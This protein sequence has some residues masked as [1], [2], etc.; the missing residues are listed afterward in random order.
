MEKPHFELGFSA[1]AEVK[2]E[3]KAQII[4]I[5]NT[6]EDL[7]DDKKQEI[8]N[9]IAAQASEESWNDIEIYRRIEELVENL[10]I[11][12]PEK[13]AQRL[14]EP[15]GHE[16]DRTKHELIAVSKPPDLPTKREKNFLPATDVLTVL[17]SEMEPSDFAFLTELLSKAEQAKPEQKIVLPFFS[18]EE[19]IARLPVI[20]KNIAFLK[21]KYTV[22]GKIILPPIHIKKIA[23]RGDRIV[24]LFIKRNWKKIGPVSFF[25]KY[26]EI[27]GQ[28]SRNK[29]YKFD[30][31]LYRVLSRNNQLD[32][33]IP[34]KK[35][36]GRKPV[37]SP[38]QNK[39]IMEANSLKM[40]VAQAAQYAGVD[41]ATISRYWRKAG[42]KPHHWRKIT[43]QALTELFWR[44][45]GNTYQAEKLCQQ[46]LNQG[47]IYGHWKK[48]GL[49][50]ILDK[51]REAY[52]MGLN[53][54]QTAE[55]IG[56][57]EEF[58]AACWRR[59]RFLHP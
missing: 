20:K 24:I 32:Q 58:V 54:T 35:V 49:V 50:E 17:K 55:Y 4:Q 31:A 42:L 44:S 51:V 52:K 39:R 16:T 23:F 30:Q 40:T 43:I 59:H 13:Y 48:M 53:Q 56:V 29:L 41:P 19:I 37:I 38:E 28:M 7:T 6:Y 45:K 2:S 27:Y 22:D 14:D 33:V 47:A 25:Q 5:L 26:P 34:E 3:I 9:K 36:A 12:W 15:I 46:R 1:P 21:A 57:D 18:K 10:H 11:P 8:T